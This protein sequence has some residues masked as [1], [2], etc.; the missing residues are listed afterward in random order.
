MP[1]PRQAPLFTYQ[2]SLTDGG[3]PAS[4]DY[5]FEFRL[6]NAASGGSTV[7]STVTVND[8]TVAAG[9]FSVALDFGKVFNNVTALWLQINVRPGASGGTYTA[10]SPR[11]PLTG[12]PYALY[13]LDGWGGTWTGTGTGLTLMGG[14]TG[15]IAKGSTYGVY[16]ENP[17]TS[18]D[19]VFG[20]ASANSGATNA[21][22]GLNL[23]PSGKGVYGEASS[24]GENYGV[25][26][27]STSPRGNGVV[28]IAAATSNTSG[29]YGIGV[30]GQ[31][32]SDFSVGVWGTTTKTS[33]STIGVYGYSNSPNGIG[34]EGRNIFG[35]Y[36]GYFEG[37]VY[38]TSGGRSYNPGGYGYLNSGGSGTSSSSSKIYDIYATGEVAALEFNAHS[39]ARIKNIQ[40]HSDG[41]AD[42]VTLSQIEI[43]DYTLKDVIANDSTPFKKVIG[44]QVEAVYPQ[45]VNLSTD[46]VPDIYQKATIKDGWVML[47]TDLQIGERVRLI[48]ENKQGIHEVLEVTRDRFRTDFVADGEAVFVYGRE[49]EDFR[50]VDYDAIAMLNVSA[51]QELNRLVEQQAAEIETIKSENEALTTRLT[52]LEQAVSAGDMAASNAASNSP[53]SPWLVFGG[54]GVVG[55]LAV[56]Q[57]RRAGE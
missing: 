34:V 3:S 22:H 25:Y 32:D 40:G 30:F 27:R 6:Y 14:T 21:V 39:D 26:G 1:W 16:G 8:Q 52:A 38:V 42:L 46:V 4:G 33:G 9:L 28:G 48:G 49:V 43:T 36:A 24:S 7:G 13:A 10:L 57:Q 41:A 44:Q 19:G 37:T 47:A 55:L 11:Q 54:L 17:S 53:L 35:G 29:D 50:N 23:S 5:D 2:G 51:T 31:A 12:T 20:F 45:A 18:G 15:L 56:V